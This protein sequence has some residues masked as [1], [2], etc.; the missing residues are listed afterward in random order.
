M[1][2]SNNHD[3]EWVVRNQLVRLANASSQD[4]Q[5]T[6]IHYANERFLYRIGVST[7][8]N[9]LILK[10]ANLFRVWTAAEIRPTR[11][12]DFLGLGEMTLEDAESIIKSLCALDLPGDGIRFREETVNSSFI[13]H[14]SG[15]GGIRVKLIAQIT[16]ARLPI[17]I[18]IGFGDVVT[19]PALKVEYPTLL[20]MPVPKIRAYPPETA[21]AEK[22][23]ILVDFGIVNSRMKDLFDL[24]VIS[25]TIS[26]N[27]R[28][29]ANAIRQTFNT[30]NTL[31]PTGI[32]L[33]LTREFA[34]DPLKRAQ[35][36]GFLRKLE[37]CS[38]PDSLEQVQQQLL[39][40][41]LPPVRSIVAN[42]NFDSV[43]EP[44][45]GWRSN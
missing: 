33:A 5:S 17:Q 1:T 27:G 3:S 7:Y 39:L 28:N 24:W 4:V 26:F 16:K 25:E 41:M 14:Q 2:N 31:I 19:P 37:D 6:M 18:D 15:Y 9:R 32:P 29:L 42:E 13:R 12:L 34:D 20:D 44:G 45:E 30:R 36:Q 43:W 21:V 38:A 10:G 40:F 35:W 22:F 23:Q 11:D 8:A